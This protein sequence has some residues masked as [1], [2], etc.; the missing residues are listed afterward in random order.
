MKL[1]YTSFQAVKMDPGSP[2]GPFATSTGRGRTLARVVTAIRRSAMSFDPVSITRARGTS[3]IPLGARGRGYPGAPGWQATPLPRWPR[4][5][6][7]RRPLLPSPDQTL[8]PGATR[9]I[10]LLADP[11]T[12]GEEAATPSTPPGPNREPVSDGEN[13]RTHPTGC[14][15]SLSIRGSDPVKA[16][17]PPAATATPRPYSYPAMVVPQVLDQDT[18]DVVVHVVGSPPTPPSPVATYADHIRYYR[19]ELEYATNFRWVAEYFDPPCGERMERQVGQ[20]ARMLL[21]S[22]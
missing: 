19:E 4:G 9:R 3:P 12:D 22:E 20:L 13:E 2:F 10:P 7:A 15:H 6:G 14:V 1:K 21:E 8:A 17:G 18:F 16:A 11:A 5:R